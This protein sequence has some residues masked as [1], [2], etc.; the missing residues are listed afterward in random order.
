MFPQQ[1]TVIVL[2]DSG[3]DVLLAGFVVDG[4]IVQNGENLLNEDGFELFIRCYTLTELIPSLSANGDVN[5]ILCAFEIGENGITEFVGS[6]AAEILVELIGTFGRS[7]DLDVNGLDIFRAD[8]FNGP[9]ERIQG[10]I[11]V[12]EGVE[13]FAFVAG[14]VETEMP[15]RAEFR[16][17]E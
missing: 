14:K 5:F 11:V 17:E 8:G 7:K 6:E 12:Q 13:E 15:L 1:E 10:F 2:A 16:A 3:G 9:V 4:R